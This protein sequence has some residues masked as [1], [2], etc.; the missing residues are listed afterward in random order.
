MYFL[1]YLE[2]NIS[3]DFDSNLILYFENVNKI[4]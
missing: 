4:F 1:N 2:L 3:S